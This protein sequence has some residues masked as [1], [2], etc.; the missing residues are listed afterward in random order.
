MY[1]T[2]KRRTRAYNNI[3]MLIL[4]LFIQY[5]EPIFVAFRRCSDFLLIF[6]SA[7]ECIHIWIQREVNVLYIYAVLRNFK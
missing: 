5:V 3:N 4:V 2:V 7:I 1:Y 6:I